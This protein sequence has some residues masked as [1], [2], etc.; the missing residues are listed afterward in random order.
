MALQRF[1]YQM[2]QET[3]MLRFFARE[4]RLSYKVKVQ[5][6]PFLTMYLT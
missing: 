6:S 3:S 4:I 5:I 1:L 2:Q